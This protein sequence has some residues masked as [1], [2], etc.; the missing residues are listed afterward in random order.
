[1]IPGLQV[2]FFLVMLSLKAK[3]KGGLCIRVGVLQLL[4]SDGGEGEQKRG[5]ESGQLH[6]TEKTFVM[7][8]SFPVSGPRDTISG[9]T[10][11]PPWDPNPEKRER[12]RAAMK[13]SVSSHVLRG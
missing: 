5:D 12:R 13:S 10:V 4:R 6:R 8:S 1:M 9:V 11:S 3:N 7:V 2:S